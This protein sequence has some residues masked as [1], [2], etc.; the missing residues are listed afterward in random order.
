M[1]LSQL[2]GAA[3][4]Y[5]AITGLVYS[6]LLSN[7]DVQTP[8]PWVNAVL[9]YVFPLFM[10]IDWLLDRMVFPLSFRQ[11]LVFLLYPVLYLAY[12]MVRGAMVDWYPYPFL[13]PRS[14]GYGFVTVMSAF[15]A[16]VGLALAWL[17]CW[18]SRRGGPDREPATGVPAR[19]SAP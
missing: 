14:N 9:H 19:G 18:V 12:T 8:I 4:L 3:T 1:W 6:L 15:V 10:V 11:G 16:V 13:E 7:A 2:R 17:V 5:M